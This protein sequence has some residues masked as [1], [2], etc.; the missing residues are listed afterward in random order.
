[1]EHPL[2]LMVFG[3]STASL[4]FHM[5]SGPPRDDGISTPMG[6]G[7]PSLGIAIHGFYIQVTAQSTAKVSL[8]NDMRLG[9]QAT[10]QPAPHRAF[11]ILE[12]QA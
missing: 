1:M 12:Q 7:A 4:P 10:M 3:S 11:C 2:I 8:T 9:A 5:L 6:S